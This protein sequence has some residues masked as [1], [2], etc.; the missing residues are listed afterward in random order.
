MRLAAGVL[1][2]AILSGTTAARADV[3][4]DGTFSIDVKGADICFIAPEALRSGAHCDGIPVPDAAAFQAV[5]DRA[6]VRGLSVGIVRAPNGGPSIGVVQVLHS[7]GGNVWPDQRAADEF[8]KSYAK[9]AAS[10]LGG[11]AKP[12][13]S[14][15]RVVRNGDTRVVRATIDMDDVP[16][17]AAGAAAEYHEIAVTFTRSWPYLVFLA[18]RRAD[19]A[20]LRAV[21]S[22]SAPTIALAAAARPHEG[23]DIGEAVGRL[24]VYV[25]MAI[26]GIAIYLSRKRTKARQ[27]AWQRQVAAQQA[28]AH[29]TAAHHDR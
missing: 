12:R 6:K 3:V 18:G 21:A 13:V 23:K 1:V 15:V 22:E 25:A 16:A 20:T 8:V 17:T 10:E 24:F 27:E 11:T 28:A 4:T 14:D 5:L 9:D 2:V 26:A 19:A 29:D 7:P